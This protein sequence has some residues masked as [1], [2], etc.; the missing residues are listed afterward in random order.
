MSQ[1]FASIIK[2]EGRV[3]NALFITLVSTMPSPH[4]MF[5]TKVLM[6]RIPTVL[7]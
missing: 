5:S 7:P 6:P 3:W 2:C 4:Q 1:I